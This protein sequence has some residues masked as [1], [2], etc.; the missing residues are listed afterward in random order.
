MADLSRR[1]RRR[2]S[3]PDTGLGAGLGLWDYYPWYVGMPRISDMEHAGK[4]Q[5]TGM[6]S[7]RRIGASSTGLIATSEGGCGILAGKGP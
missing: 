5:I 2:N 7:C 6:E 1:F 4:C 3:D